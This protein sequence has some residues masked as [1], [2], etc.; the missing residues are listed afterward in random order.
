MKKIKINS[1]PKSPDREQLNNL[2]RDFLKTAG[3][4]IAGSILMPKFTRSS[5]SKRIKNVGIQLYTVRKEMIED[6]IAT[7]KKL[8]KIGFK[9]LESARSEKGNYYGLSPIEIKKIVGDL[10]MKILSGHIHVD[11]DWKKSIEEAT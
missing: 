9:E 5:S 10:G 2:R 8:A 1:I 7:L 6:P 3:L 4:V 11:K